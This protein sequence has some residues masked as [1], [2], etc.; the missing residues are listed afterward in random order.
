MKT[1]SEARVIEAK[2]LP[3]FEDFNE[4]D[5]QEDELSAIEI[6]KE[7][8]DLVDKA[9][10]QAKH[11]IDSAK[12][13][14]LLI[15]DDAEL[16]KQS[17]LQ[18]IQEESNRLFAEAKGVGQR[19][20]FEEGYQNGLESATVEYQSRME[21]VNYLLQQAVHQQRAELL[22]A[23][24]IIIDLAFTIAKKI[25]F[26]NPE[27]LKEQIVTSVA[28]T[29]SKVRDNDK[30]E[31]IVN[32]EDFDIVQNALPSL[33]SVLS[34]KSDIVLQVEPEVEMGSC[35]IHTELGTVDAKLSTQFDEIKKA[36]QSLELGSDS[37]AEA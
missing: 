10:Q 37:I 24:S 32:P 21:Q 20:G 29:L 28:R 23:Q 33:K 34:G 27:L 14:A 1:I 36:L 22:E 16:Q 11:I 25:V 2:P 18:Q 4:E 13:E 15:V 3:V 35:M 7:I 5:T 12:Q 17:L 30:V 8:Q 19:E 26:Q 6:P 9:N 31:I